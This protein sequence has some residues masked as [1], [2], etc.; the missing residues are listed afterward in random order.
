M[1]G[2]NEPVHIADHKIEIYVYKSCTLCRMFQK[3]YYARP[4]LKSRVR[5]EGCDCTEITGTCCLSNVC[6]CDLIEGHYGPCRWVGKASDKYDSLFMHDVF[7]IKG[8]ET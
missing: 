3:R 2:R 5:P 4:T 8:A 1:R 7:G 6:D